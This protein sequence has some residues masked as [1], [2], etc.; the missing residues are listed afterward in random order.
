M[1]LLSV[2]IKPVSGACNMRCRYCFY[3]DVM[4]HRELPTQ[5]PMSL[6]TLECLVR[7][8]CH[9]ADGSLSFALQGGEPTLA[10]LPFLQALVGFQKIYN[11]RHVPLTNAVQTNG[12]TLPDDMIAF[13]A[14]EDFLVGVSLDG[15]ADTHDPWRIDARG[16]GTFLAVKANIERL[17]RA[18]VR[19]NVLCVVH[20]EVAGQPEKTFEALANY[21]HIQFIPCLDGL[22]GHTEPYAL[23]QE[24][25]AHFLTCIFDRYEKRFYERKPV[26]IRNFD[27]LLGIMLGM[28]PD[29]CAMC[30]RCQANY[31]VEADGGV[32]PCDFYVLDQ[33]RLGYVQQSNFL[34]LA[35]SPVAQAFREAS[36]PLPE[37]CARCQWYPLCRNGCKRERDAQTNVYR[38]C[39][40]MQLFLSDCAQRM[41]QMADRMEA[42]QAAFPERRD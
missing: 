10:G 35:N 40:A 36:F 4:A 42:Q 6:E 19:V 38:F 27:N 32:Y 34:R 17:R 23:T 16:Q 29:N 18:G 11:T 28:P 30:G 15:A 37:K 2:M 31:V 39:G 22:D 3:R 21:E 25:Y 41:R 8:A 14:Q 5:A 7:R 9:Y 13:F 20:A 24:R 1:P 12:F 26:H 33:Y